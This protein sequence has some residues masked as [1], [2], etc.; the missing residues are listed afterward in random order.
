M[1][2]TDRPQDAIELARSAHAVLA[3]RLG[4]MGERGADP[5]APS[6]L[7]GW[8]VGHV[9]T[10]IARNADGLRRLLEGAE[11][12]ETADMYP[13]GAPARN[14]AIDAGASRDWAD[15]LT[16]VRATAAELESRFDRQVRWDGSGRGS[17]GQTFLAVDVPFIRCREVFV[18]LADLGDAGFTA[19]DWPEHYVEQ[20]LAGLSRRWRERHGDE[21]LP[22]AV[23][24]RSPLDRVR[25]LLG[26][27]DVDG[28]DAAG[29]L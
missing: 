1:L 13:G 11:R 29:I 20:E 9:V 24:D 26:R 16:D 8:S 21:R 27:L 19:Q 5:A 17:A 6:L 23:A 2:P 3:A 7:P 4:A 28:T 12:G 10:H 15:L 22:A 18:H 25:W 14:A